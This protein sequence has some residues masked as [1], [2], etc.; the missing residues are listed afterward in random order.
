MC[1]SDVLLVTLVTL[2]SELVIRIIDTDGAYLAEL[3]WAPAEDS[4]T[5]LTAPVSCS[6][7]PWWYPLALPPMAMLV[8]P[9]MEFECEWV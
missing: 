8:E 7:S 2:V 3:G 4:G 9:E 5:D 1:A 6:P